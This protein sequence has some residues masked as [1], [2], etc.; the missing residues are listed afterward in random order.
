[1]TTWMLQGTSFKRNHL[2]HNLKI[3]ES[4]PEVKAYLRK[5]VIWVTWVDY[6]ILIWLVISPDSDSCFQS[7]LHAW[8]GG[9]VFTHGANT[10]TFGEAIVG[11]NV[12][13][14]LLHCLLS[15]KGAVVGLI[16]VHYHCKI[17]FYVY[18]HTGPERPKADQY[19]LYWHRRN[20]NSMPLWVGYCEECT[21]H[22]LQHCSSV[23]ASQWW[24]S[25]ER[26]APGRDTE[27]GVRRG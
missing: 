16:H 2:K 11:L 22:R 10:D 17:A 3:A 12:V 1:M 26:T 27:K 23:P 4:D 15:Q 20:T 8:V 13:V 25:P 18:L 7:S 19:L 6:S 21:C 9:W 14:E 5:W 24:S